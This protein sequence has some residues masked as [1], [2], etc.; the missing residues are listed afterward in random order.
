MFDV[1]TAPLS[2]RWPFRHFSLARTKNET[3]PSL[4]FCDLLVAHIKMP[5][6][7]ACELSSLRG[8]VAAEQQSSRL[9]GFA[10]QLDFN[11]RYNSG[12]R[13]NHCYRSFTNRT[14]CIT[15][16]HDHKCM[17]IIMGSFRG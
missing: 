10:F 4:E 13:V 6:L 12:V 1:T 3:T 11:E 17:Y 7:A 16:L 8:K 9:S 2:F 15:R 5:D 14:L